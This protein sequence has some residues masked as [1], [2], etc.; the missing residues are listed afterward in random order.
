[1]APLGGRS[2]HI[3]NARQREDT[4]L[5]IRLDDAVVRGS[6]VREGESIHVYTGGT[7]IVLHY[8]D[9]L[10]HAGE[11]EVE[12]GR[13][14]APMPSKIVAL[15]TEKGRD[16]EKGAPFLIM[17]AMKMEHTASAPTGGI[18]EELLCSVSDQV[19]EGVQLLAFKAA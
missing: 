8:G 1:M 5:T 3:G 2:A 11:V 19:A 18:V 7:H 9:P 16:V 6:V 15:L 17:E 14:T 4:Q 13:L 12:G 10:A